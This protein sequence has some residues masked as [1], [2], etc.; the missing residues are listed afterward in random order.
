MEYSRDPGFAPVG[1]YD[2]LF[3]VVDAR[4]GDTPPNP[5]VIYHA[6]LTQRHPD[7]PLLFEVKLFGTA[8][9]FAGAV[10]KALTE[11]CA[12]GLGANRCPFDLDSVSEVD[13]PVIDFADPVPVD[14]A[15]LRFDTPVKIKT[16]RDGVMWSLDFELLVRNILRR[17]QALDV[18]RFDI[19]EV[20]GLC[21]RA[22]GIHIERSDLSPHMMERWSNRTA[23]KKSLSGLVGTI[24]FTGDLTEF[25]PYIY[26]GSLVHVGKSCTMGLGHYAVFD[27]KCR[28]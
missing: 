6:G 1:V 28:I 24:T 23:S 2:E 16:Y 9:R 17:L 26:A 15:E 11:G 5:Y 13:G 4:T 27:R 21:S 25:L 22:M 8:M 10:T 12:E 7:E 18:M 19:A 20:E 14:R 3:S